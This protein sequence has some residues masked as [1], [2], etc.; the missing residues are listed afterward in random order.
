MK[1]PP[2]HPPTYLGDRGTLIPKK[3]HIRALP[4]VAIE[5]IK[6]ESRVQ[7]S[8]QLYR[9]RRYTTETAGPRYAAA[10]VKRPFRWLHTCE[11]RGREEQTTHETVV[12]RNPF[13]SCWLRVLATFLQNRNVGVGRCNVPRSIGRGCDDQEAARIVGETLHLNSTSPHS[14]IAIVS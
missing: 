13:V 12:Y 10:D 11:T 6:L 4:L 1:K 9:S 2:T 5:A 3:S 7:W 14:L 8:D